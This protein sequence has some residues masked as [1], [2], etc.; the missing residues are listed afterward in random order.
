[1]KRGLLII[2]IT[3]SVTAAIVFGSRVSADALAVV[4]GVVLG[5]VASVP[6]TLLVIFI[7]TRQRSGLDRGVPPA[8]Q[9]PPV[10]IVNAPDRASLAVPPTLP[11]PY[12]ADQSRKWTVVGDIET[13]S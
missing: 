5:I 4:V 7:L 10:V 13:D 8:T 3:F 9:N 12:P 6:T 2:G 11:A 1:M